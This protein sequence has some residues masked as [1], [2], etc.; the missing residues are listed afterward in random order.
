MS[1]YLLPGV[2]DDVEEVI[3]SPSAM[4]ASPAATGSAA[5]RPT[6]DAVMDQ[7]KYLLIGAGVTSD[8]AEIQVR[9]MHSSLMGELPA[10]AAA[11]PPQPHNELSEIMIEDMIERSVT[12]QIVAVERRFND[13]RGILEA[14][15]DALR[16]QVALLK[17]PPPAPKPVCPEPSTSKRK[18]LSPKPGLSP[19]Q[20][21]SVFN[22]PESPTHIAPALSPKMH[23][24]I[25]PVPVTTSSDSITCR[26]CGKFAKEEHQRWK[27]AFRPIRCHGCNLEVPAKEYTAHVEKC[28]TS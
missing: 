15:I 17:S 2:N 21:P 13:M 24:T 6:L 25:A 14:E 19:P 16:T 26:W 12:K 10:P 4:I 11:A 5:T 3:L 27:C 20:S 7:I 18:I 8:A 28:T 1:R 23:K 22:P 9:R